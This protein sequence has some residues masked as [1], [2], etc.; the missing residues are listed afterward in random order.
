MD[1]IDDTGELR[2]ATHGSDPIT[3]IRY[4]L[5]MHLRLDPRCVADK[6]GAPVSW[7]PQAR[8]ARGGVA[9][10]GLPRP[11]IALTTLRAALG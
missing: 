1:L 6:L 8:P 4:K 2:I 11:L 9:L 10:A 3:R 5:A 7:S